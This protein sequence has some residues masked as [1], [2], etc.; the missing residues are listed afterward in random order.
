[1]CNYVDDLIESYKIEF[2]KWEENNEEL[3]RIEKLL[4][5]ERNKIKKVLDD[6]QNTHDFKKEQVRFKEM[7]RRDKEIVDK[8]NSI[9]FWYWK[10]RLENN[11]K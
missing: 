5:T 1:M 3:S 11:E 6:S 7:I 10:N 2:D 9:L 8:I 4:M